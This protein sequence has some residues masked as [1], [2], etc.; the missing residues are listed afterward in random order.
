[1]LQCRAL[2]VIKLLQ[3][4]LYV[5]PI[6]IN[7]TSEKLLPTLYTDIFFEI[8]I[9]FLLFTVICWQSQWQHD[10]KSCTHWCSQKFNRFFQFYCPFTP[11]III[12]LNV[13][14]STEFLSH[15]FESC[16][17]VLFVLGNLK[18]D[19]LKC[20]FSENIHLHLVSFVVLSLI[21]FDP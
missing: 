6:L 20:E 18:T 14:L 4:L 5:A 11:Q 21:R 9:L 19:K 12:V 16:V 2:T 3:F 15:P 1:M 8:S 17:F 13:A 10:F 7:Q